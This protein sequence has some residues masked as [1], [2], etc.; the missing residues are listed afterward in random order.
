MNE[1]LAPRVAEVRRGGMVTVT[2]N[3]Q[4]VAELRPVEHRV[5]TPSFD[6]AAIAD[7]RAFHA[8]LPF[9]EETGAAITRRLRDE[10]C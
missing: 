5:E 3:G 10:G 4:S 1:A 2:K 7:L 6:A 9:S 8:T